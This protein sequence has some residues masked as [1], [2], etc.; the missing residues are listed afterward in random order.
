[1]LI[2]HAHVYFSIQMIYYF[3]LIYYNYLLSATFWFFFGFSFGFWFFFGWG[4]PQP[5]LWSRSMV[6]NYWTPQN[7][8]QIQS[9]PGRVQEL[10][11]I[12][13]NSCLRLIYGLYIRTCVIMNE[14]F[15]QSM[16]A[17]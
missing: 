6:D 8:K 16:K 12:A 5:T 9:M 13:M 15:N 7:P 14:Y 3:T 17:I 2:W 11:I 10:E 1:M 4:S